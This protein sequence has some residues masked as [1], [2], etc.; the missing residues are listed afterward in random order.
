[1]TK[2]NDIR[3]AGLRGV[4]NDIAVPLDGKSVLIYGDNGTG[5]ST[6]SDVLEWFYYGKV[7][8]LSSKDIGI[9]WREALRNIFL[10]KNQQAFVSLEF[11]KAEY[12]CKKSIEIKKGKLEE[13]KSN[14]SESFDDY[15]RAS[16]Q[17]NI[18]LR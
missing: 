1:M 7:K 12:N 9:N 14:T 4:R 13:E 15:L 2:I 6:L 11:S 10:S 17:E 8:H 18:I 16:S 3:V 5:K